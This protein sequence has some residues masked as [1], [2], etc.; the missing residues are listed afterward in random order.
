MAPGIFMFE[1]FLVRISAAGIRYC[2]RCPMLMCA[3]ARNSC[4]QSLTQLA[5]LFCSC[6]RL[7][8]RQ[9]GA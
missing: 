1:H 7:M 8:V 4:L 3:C 9:R 6:R 2:T 5:S